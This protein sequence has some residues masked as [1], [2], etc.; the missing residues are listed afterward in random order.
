M[1]NMWE[2]LYFTICVAVLVIAALIL[3]DQ[4]VF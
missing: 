4:G 3:H 2:V 1:S